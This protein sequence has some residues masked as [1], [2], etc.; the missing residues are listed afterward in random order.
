MRV[1]AETKAET[2]TRI[3]EAG[4]K[5][6]SEKGFDATTTRELAAAA[7]IAAGTLFNYFGSKEALALAILGEALERGR[8][9]FRAARLGTEALDEDLFAFLA[10]GL[11]ELRPYRRFAGPVFEAAMSPFGTSDLAL[12]GASLRAD[13][14]EEVHGIL[15]THGTPAPADP[16]GMHL[17]WTLHLGVLAF[18]THDESPR[19]EDTLVVLD[20]AM[21]LFAA[22]LGGTTRETREGDDR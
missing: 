2:R 3:L 12:E 13:S 15:A 14:L 5:A 20:R 22:S 21:N 4:R 11:R 10:A 19:Q 17:F 8:E 6:F 18:W 9:S 1:S 16:V 7:G